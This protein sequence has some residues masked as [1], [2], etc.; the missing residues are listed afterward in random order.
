MATEV[1]T[2]HDKCLDMENTSRSILSFAIFANPS[3]FQF[4][5]ACSPGYTNFQTVDSSRSN[6]RLATQKCWKMIIITKRNLQRCISTHTQPRKDQ[7]VDKTFRFWS[8]FHLF[9]ELSF[10]S[11]VVS[12]LPF[13]GGK[14]S[15]FLDNP[16]PHQK[17]L[18]H[19]VPF[20]PSF[21]TSCLLWF[22][23]AYT[24]TLLV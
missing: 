6:W 16:P 15:L 20:N 21:P 5:N 4:A 7:N 22:L 23:V 2:I 10:K 14:V 13:L 17:T 19:I 1:W 18:G 3:I 12:F 8:S 24:T 9:V 11:C